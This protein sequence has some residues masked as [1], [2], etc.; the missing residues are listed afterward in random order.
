MKTVR[1]ARLMSRWGQRRRREYAILIALASWD[2][3]PF[4]TAKNSGNAITFTPS[5]FLEK[6][7]S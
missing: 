2:P 1:P 3:E 7:D 6:S 5:T 4:W